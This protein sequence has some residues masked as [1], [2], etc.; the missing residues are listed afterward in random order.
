MTW[1]YGNQSNQNS[2]REVNINKFLRSI[3]FFP[4]STST[5]AI[6]EY[7]FFYSTYTSVVYNYVVKY[8]YIYSSWLLFSSLGFV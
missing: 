1:A 7:G 6:D 8:K 4:L 2:K 3:V 5:G